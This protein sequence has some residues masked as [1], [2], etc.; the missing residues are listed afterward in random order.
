MIWPETLSRLSVEEIQRP[1]ACGPDPVLCGTAL[2]EVA[3]TL[4][5]HDLT[6]MAP[7]M[8]D[9]EKLYLRPHLSV[10]P[11]GTSPVLPKQICPRSPNSRKET[12]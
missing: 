6:V 10:R 2:H 1:I 8:G 9:P 4:E 12:P 3:R 7:G 5:G 11:D